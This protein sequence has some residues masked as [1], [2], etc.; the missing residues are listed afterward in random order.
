MGKTTKMGGF[1][2]VRLAADLR[3]RLEV[4]AAAANRGLSEYVRLKLAEIAP[5]KPTRAVKKRKKR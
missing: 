4:Q 2:R 1:L 5:T 3:T